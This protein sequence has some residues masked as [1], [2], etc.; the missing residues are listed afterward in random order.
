MSTETATYAMNNTDIT[1][2]PTV[3]SSIFDKYILEFLYRY[4]D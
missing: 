4:K 3:L 1:Y 2:P